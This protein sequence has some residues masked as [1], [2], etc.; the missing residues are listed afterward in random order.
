MNYYWNAIKRP[1][2]DWSKLLIGIIISIIPIVNFMA[3]GYQIRCA[4]T[5]SQMKL[6]KW[7]KFGQLFVSGVLSAVII[8][9]YAL[10]GLIIFGGALGTALAS[11]IPELQTAD[12][13][14]IMSSVNIGFAAG[15]FMVVGLVLM[16]LGGL[17]GSSG[18]IRY[19]QRLRFKDAFNKE[20]F[21]KAFTGR[22]FLTW[23]LIGIYGAA[24]SIIFSILPNIGFL[25]L[26]GSISGFLYGVT[27]MTALGIIYK[28]L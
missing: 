12:L 4:K 17:V 14:N 11:F 18:L 6:P 15:I 28:K 10:P 19:S 21:R 25:D 8:L 16:V 27:Y 3:M 7:D 22:F 23:V 5:S 20:V 9:I 24:L 1:F 13:S 2:T 26:E